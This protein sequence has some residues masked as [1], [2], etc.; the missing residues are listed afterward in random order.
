MNRQKNLNIK[1][2]IDHYTNRCVSHCISHCINHCIMY[3]S[4]LSNFY[5][6]EVYPENSGTIY[7]SK[8]KIKVRKLIETIIN[9]MYENNKNIII[10]KSI[11][12]NVYIN[13]SCVN[14]QQ[15]KY[16]D[17]DCITFP[18]DNNQTVHVSLNY[19][20]NIRIIKY[21]KDDDSIHYCFIDYNS[22]I[23]EIIKEFRNIGC[24]KFY[25]PMNK[26]LNKSLAISTLV[27]NS[28]GFVYIY[29]KLQIKPYEIINTNNDVNVESNVYSGSLYI[30]QERE[31]VESKKNIYKIGRTNK[32]IDERLHG[33]PKGTSLLLVIGVPQNSTVQLESELINRFKEQFKNRTDIGK[34]YFEGN[35]KDMINIMFNFVIDK[36]YLT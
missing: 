19:S 17:D 24:S 25:D 4:N 28:D 10:H 29:S 16:S 14:T 5:C 9:K 30:L 11:L 27:P 21:V 22:G 26:E 35:I 33:Y 2:G 12:T 15:Y 6:H 18:T 34:E 31:H 13:V 23:N 7:L 36:I 3:S 1:P 8:N 32:S 20:G